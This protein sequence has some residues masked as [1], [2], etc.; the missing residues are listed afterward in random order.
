MTDFEGHTD[1]PHAVPP[2][3]PD[4]PRPVTGRVKRRAL[5]DKHVKV[6]WMLGLALLAITTY[7]AASRAYAW[8]RE[9]RLISHGQKVMAEV[10][11]WEPGNPNTPKGKVVQADTPVDILYTVNGTSYRPYGQLAGRTKQITT[12]EIIPIFIDPADPT[13]FTARTEPATLSHELVGVMMLAPGVLLLLAVALWQWW[14][15]ISIYRGG[16]AVLAEVLSVGHSASGPASR[17][18]RC[19]VHQGD[20][21]RIIKTVLPARQTPNPGELLWLIA[22]PGRPHLGVPAILFQ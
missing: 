21:D 20:N 1:S 7:Y 16:E 14:R 4:A 13:R 3:P 2:Q 12:G 8:S 6:W 22:P 15:V 11:S 9:T 18:V 17:L 5:R 10:K 19:A